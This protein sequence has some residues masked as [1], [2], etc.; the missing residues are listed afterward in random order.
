MS[1]R[2]RIRLT[3]PVEADMGP[4][5]ILATA[6]KQQRKKQRQKLGPLQSL[7]IKPATV[8]R[9]KDNLGRFYQF[10]SEER[11]KLAKDLPAL[12]NQISRYISHLWDSGD[13]LSYGSNCVAAI[14]HFSPGLKHKLPSSWRLLS[15][16][17]KQELPARAPPMPKSVVHAIAEWGFRNR[18]PE[19]AL[20]VLIGWYVFLR[21]GEFLTLQNRENYS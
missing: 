12:D 3:A 19:F 10:L 7:V 4:K 17:R 8:K 18:L 13:P 1:A 14:Q 15:A 5:Q 20:I 6:N 9:Y 21:T 16:W 2:R 11:E